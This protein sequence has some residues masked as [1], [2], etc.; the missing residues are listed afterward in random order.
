MTKSPASETSRER[1]T[2]L[3]AHQAELVDPRST[4]PALRGGR[5]ASCGYRFFPFQT[6]GCERCGAH[7][8]QIEPLALP[9]RGQLQNMAAI[10][11]R[12]E[13][14]E[15]FVTARVLLEPGLVIRA[16]LTGDTRAAKPGATVIGRLVETEENGP[17]ELRF[18]VQA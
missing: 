6:Y 8:E 17:G 18:E 2:P 10:Q 5:C 1:S 7:G 13:G 16:L 15:S 11:S 12:E 9:C 14:G 3:V 4:P